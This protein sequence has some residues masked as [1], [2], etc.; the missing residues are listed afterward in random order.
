M[1]GG[2]KTHNQ[3]YH[4]SD[5]CICYGAI[6]PEVVIVA[7]NTRATMVTVGISPTVYHGDRR[8]YKSNSFEPLKKVNRTS[9]AWFNSLSKC[10]I[11]NHGKRNVGSDEEFHQ[12]K[13]KGWLVEPHFP[14]SC[15]DGLLLEG[16]G[17]SCI[18]LLKKCLLQ[19]LLF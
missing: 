3:Y 9:F 1:Q 15:Y 16:F 7:V 18:R 2:L 14:H 8:R 5:N 4:N 12:C 17:N 6:E 11:F 13:L 19:P 10:W